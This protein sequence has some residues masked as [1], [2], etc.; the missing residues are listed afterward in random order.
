MNFPRAISS[1]RDDLRGS[2]T[3]EFVLWLPFLLAWVV[4]SL[5]AFKAMENRSDAAKATYT[6]S[7][8]ISRRNEVN[9]AFMS[10]LR[11]LAEQVLPSSAT[12]ARM[13]VSLIQLKDDT[14]EV[15]WTECFGDILPLTDD[16]IPFGLV[17]DAMSNLDTIVLTETFVPYLPISVPYPM[18]IAIGPEGL[19]WTN[20]I[21]TRPRDKAN[22]TNPDGDIANCAQQQPLN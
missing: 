20:S 12:G 21:V 5:A 10:D 1:F 2:I 9:R 16:T 14:L 6:I 13:R 15:Q 3:L 17:P 4:F 7:D 19:V 22:I 11:D 8:I 18:S